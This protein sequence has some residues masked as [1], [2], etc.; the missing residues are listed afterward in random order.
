[1][2]YAVFAQRKVTLTG[3]INTISLQQTQRSNEQFVLATN[4]LSLQQEL[5]SQQAA[6]SGQLAELY[7]KL[8]GTSNSDQRQSIQNE[9]R[10]I[11]ERFKQE[12]DE[13]KLAWEE[14]RAEQ[15]KVNKISITISMVTTTILLTL[16]IILLNKSHEFGRMMIIPPFIFGIFFINIIIV[17]ISLFFRKKQRKYNN[18]FKGTIIKKLIENFY[19]NVEYFPNKQMLQ[20]IYDEPKYNEFYNRY[21][22]DDYIEAKINNKYDIGIAEVKTVH[23]TTRMSF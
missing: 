17:I 21:Y 18:I 13:I 1:M 7:E 11:E 5:S 10:A 9:I 3:R 19:N 8:A 15:K 23:E 16:M 20:R 2:G 4:T 14:A 6:Q 22:S 12:N